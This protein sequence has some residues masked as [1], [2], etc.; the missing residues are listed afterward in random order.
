MW[1]NSKITKIEANREEISQKWCFR[2]FDRTF[3]SVGFTME[4]LITFWRWRLRTLVST[5]RHPM[6]NFARCIFWSSQ[7]SHN[8]AIFTLNFKLNILNLSTIYNS[9]GSRF[10]EKFSMLRWIVTIGW[11]KDDTNFRSLHPQKTISNSIVYKAHWEKCSIGHSKNT[12][13]AISLHD[14]PRFW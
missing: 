12:I 10:R 13:S 1:E 2:M 3:F 6:V 8:L 5:L 7:S 14:W 9:P 4:L 11:R